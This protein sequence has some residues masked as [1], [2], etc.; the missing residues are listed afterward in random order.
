M[1]TCY[2]C[3]G[4]EVAAG[5]CA[6]RGGTGLCAACWAQLPDRVR[7]TVCHKPFRPGLRA[8]YHSARRRALALALLWAEV[9][10]V[11]GVSMKLTGAYETFG[12]VA[13]VVMGTFMSLA[14]VIEA[15]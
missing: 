11:V 12:F 7:C 6:C 2:V 14:V 15:A 1:P 5:I 9:F 3:L 8:L 13:A 4:D 10:V